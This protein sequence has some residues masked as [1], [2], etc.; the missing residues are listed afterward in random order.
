MSTRTPCG[1]P[2]VRSASLWLLATLGACGHSGPFDPVSLPEGLLP[3]SPTRMTYSPSTDLLLGHRGARR[4]V[5]YQ[6]CPVPDRPGEALCHD[7]DRCVGA[8][9]AGG[10]QRRV[11]LCGPEQ[12]DRDSIQVVQAAAEAADGSLAWTYA[13]RPW[14]ASFSTSPGLFVRRPGEAAGRRVLDFPATLSDALVPEALW[15]VTPAAVIAVTGGSAVRI[16]LGRGDAAT[17]TP[18]DGVVEAVDPIRRRLVRRSGL[19]LAWRPMDG[20]GETTFDVA[21][22]EGWH[23]ASLAAVSATNG[24]IAVLQTANAVAGNFDTR[25]S[26]VVLLHEDGRLVEL[27]RDVGVP[28]SALSLDPQ[29]DAVV[30]ESR[31]TTDPGTPPHA[32]LFLQPVRP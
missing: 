26:R 4:L 14:N 15:W 18:L 1:R 17:V 11:S 19:A 25:V 6:Y 27:R 28:W 13:A 10:G 8:L 5:F 22:P 2:P 7:Q 3:A 16:D 29:G 24:R 21:V 31:T 23:D 30:L 20:G 9:P 12:A 32:D